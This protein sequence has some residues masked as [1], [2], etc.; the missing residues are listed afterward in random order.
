[1]EIEIISS[2]YGAISR[3]TEPG[4]HISVINPQGKLLK[5]Q[6]GELCRRAANNGATGMREMPFW[7]EK[8]EDHIFAPYKYAKGKYNLAQFN[9]LYFENLRNVAEIANHFK[10][11]FYLS[12]YEHCNIKPR[13]GKAAFVPW[14]NN[15]QNLENAWYGKDA[16]GFRN[17]W[18]TKILATLKDLNAGYELCN[19]PLDDDFQ[20]SGFETYKFLVKNGIKDENI[21]TGV[22][23][24]T[25]QYRNFREPF[26]EHYGDQW[27]NKQKHKWF[28]T[29][30]NLQESTFEKLKEQEG[31]TRRYWLS[32][33][34]IQPK[35][36]KQWWENSLSK[37]F[38]TVPTAPFKNKYAF[39][40]MHKRKRDD[41]DDARGIAEALCKVKKYNPPNFN[42]FSNPVS[43]TF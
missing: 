17:A 39:E 11:K 18:E 13:L 7:L 29:V 2:Y 20:H 33:D 6:W 31:H 22:E 10:L 21:I 41:F 34:G 40:T 1:M 38:E 9:S 43:G 37:F 27:W 24:D 23:W 30:H 5:R 28:S 12:L 36:T 35:P 16:D 26:L 8:K 25:K 19:E 3:I 15:I 14:S 4:Y 42:K 32:V